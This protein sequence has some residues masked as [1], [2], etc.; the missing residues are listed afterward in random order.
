MR[1]STWQSGSF[2]PD[3]GELAALRVPGT[4]GTMP[5]G[6]ARYRATLNREDVEAILFS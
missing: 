4:P 2:S 5:G 6:R 1:R 3:D